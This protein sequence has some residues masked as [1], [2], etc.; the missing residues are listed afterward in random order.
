MKSAASR[1]PALMSDVATLLSAPA[2]I[3][4]GS[5]IR[6]VDG[7]RWFRYA[8]ESKNWSMRM[9]QD[10]T[11]AR[12]VRECRRATACGYCLFLAA[13]ALET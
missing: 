10:S 13:I 11:C 9:L 2:C 1:S 6:V 7:P 5:T 8:W 4:C 3:G 12:T